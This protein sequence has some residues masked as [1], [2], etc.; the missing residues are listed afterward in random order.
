MII[1]SIEERKATFNVDV[2]T[3]VAGNVQWKAVFRE[4]E[5]ELVNSSSNRMGGLEVGPPGI[6][7]ISPIQP[8]AHTAMPSYP[9]RQPP[10]AEEKRRVLGAFHNRENSLV[11]AGV[12]GIS[13]QLGR[14]GQQPPNRQ[15][16]HHQV[17]GLCVHTLWLCCS[18][19]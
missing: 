4:S 1:L 5:R 3:P 11:D 19:F 18:M 10:T 12:G 13:L 9:R 7:Y 6:Q 8:P 14:A 16:L 15:A 2:H 17:G